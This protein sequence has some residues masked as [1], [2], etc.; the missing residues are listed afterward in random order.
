LE[1]ILKNGKLALKFHYSR[2]AINE[3]VTTRISKEEPI[4]GRLLL[5]IPDDHL[6]E[7]SSGAALITVSIFDYRN[8]ESTAEF[9]AG[10]PCI[11]GLKLLPK[12]NLGRLP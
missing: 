11:D 12:E 7:I 4:T 1:G 3:K 9:K 10:G 8:H 6:D 5:N 2:D